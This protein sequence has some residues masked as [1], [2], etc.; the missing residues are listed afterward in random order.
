[1]EGIITDRNQIIHGVHFP[2]ADKVGGS[3]VIKEV[4][5]E[6]R[7]IKT[8]MVELSTPTLEE[9]VNYVSQT[10]RTMLRVREALKE[11]KDFDK[12]LKTY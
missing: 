10:G 4:M 12:I 3:V 7:G 11:E 6:K 8:K 2:S 1:M 5:H 9:Y